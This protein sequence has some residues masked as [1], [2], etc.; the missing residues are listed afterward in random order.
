MWAMIHFLVWDGKAAS[1][2]DILASVLSPGSS[3][4][5]LNDEDERD[6]EDDHNHE[7]NHDNYND[8]NSSHTNE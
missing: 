4:D 1:T 5:D 7:D 2:D 3:V 8:G 6:D